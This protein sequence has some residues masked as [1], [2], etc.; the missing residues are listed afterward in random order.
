MNNITISRRHFATKA[1]FTHL[2]ISL[3]IALLI[4]LIV[5]QIWYPNP[6]YKMIGSLKLMGLIMLVDLVCGPLLTLIVA[7][8][9]K[10]KKEL[11]RDFGLIGII[12]LAAL[13]YG[14]YALAQ[15]RPV[16]LA[17][18]KDRFYVATA[19]EI[20]PDRLAKAPEAFRS[21]PLF[22]IYQVG[23]RNPTNQEEFLEGINLSMAGIPPAAR[24]D[25]WIPR[26]QV[27]KNI[28]NARIPLKTLLDQYPDRAAV[29]RQYLSNTAK[30][31]NLY[32]LPLTSEKTL[33]WIMVF[34]DKNEAVAYVPVDGFQ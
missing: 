20:E 1:F 4:S 9:A 10:P 19:V 7:N 8:P 25:W 29:I 17:F 31:D 23:T 6:Y 27:E 30:T 14:L 26:A 33:D 13:C 11:I 21:L 3:L 16:A 34:N 22:G 28:T 18:D 15:S 24:P 5:F 2:S 12:Q 32:Y